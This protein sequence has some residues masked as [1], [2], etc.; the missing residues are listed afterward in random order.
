M[1]GERVCWG[2]GWGGTGKRGTCAYALKREGGA[3]LA[4]L[5]QNFR[6]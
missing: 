4:G 2:G 6:A 5:W 1:E 3:S